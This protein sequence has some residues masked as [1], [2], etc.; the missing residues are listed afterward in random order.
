M[1]SGFRRLQAYTTVAGLAKF[2]G[3]SVRT[4]HFYHRIGLL[5]PALIGP[6]GYRY[7]GESE[8]ARFAK[9]VTYRRLGLELRVIRRLLTSDDSVQLGILKDEQRRMHSDLAR[10]RRLIEGLEELI[11]SLEGQETA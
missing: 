10:R 7:Y 5:E 3:V 2:S 4:L 8:R 9:I 1:D 11:E 6:N